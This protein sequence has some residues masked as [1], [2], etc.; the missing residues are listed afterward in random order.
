MT[1]RGSPLSMAGI[2]VSA[3]LVVVAVLV[4]PPGSLPRLVVSLTIWLVFTGVLVFVVWLILITAYRRRHIHDIRLRDASA[5]QVPMRDF[6][7]SWDAELRALG[8]RYLGALELTGPL[9]RPETWW[10][11]ADVDGRIGAEVAR[12]RRYVCFSTAFLDGTTVVTRNRA[13]LPPVQLTS[14]TSLNVEAA[15]LAQVYQAHL[16][17]L[18]TRAA[19]H[20]DAFRRQD[21]ADVLAVEERTR[22]SL[23]REVPGMRTWKAR[24]TEVLLLAV[25]FAAWAVQTLGVL[26]ILGRG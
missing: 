14:Y 20:G 22:E 16:V 24:A 19:E 7:R 2:V 18:Q 25:V 26:D 5:E 23:V 4:W 10:N 3:A 6:E 21:M 11:Y 1:S 17:Q 15:S 12:R 9:D 13:V 8:F